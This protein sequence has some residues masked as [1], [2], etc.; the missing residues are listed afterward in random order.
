MI[1]LLLL[2][3]FSR[4]AAAFGLSRP[5]YSYY[6]NVIMSAC[7][8]GDILLS[9]DIMFMDLEAPVQREVERVVSDQITVSL[10]SNLMFLGSEHR[11]CLW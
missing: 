9:R 4:T 7:W 10:K 2:T 6:L 1:D 3:L 5:P 11:A 8:T